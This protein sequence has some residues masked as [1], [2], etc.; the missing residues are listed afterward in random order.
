M[1]FLQ[2]MALVVALAGLAFAQ[3]KRVK[4]TVTDAEV[5]KGSSAPRS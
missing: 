2:T 4:R 3:P 5:E 1:T